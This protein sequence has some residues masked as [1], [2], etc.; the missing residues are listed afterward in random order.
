MTQASAYSGPLYWD[1]EVAMGIQES[2]KFT[3]KMISTTVFSSELTTISKR[4][5]SC[6]EADKSLEDT[7]SDLCFHNRW[8]AGSTEQ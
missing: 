7:D 5:S 3:S 6:Q 2:K 8:M 4:A 1:V